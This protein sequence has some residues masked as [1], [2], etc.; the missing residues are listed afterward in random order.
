MGVSQKP[1]RT[2]PDESLLWIRCGELYRITL[3]GDVM[4]FD[5][6]YDGQTRPCLS[7]PVSACRWHHLEI[8]WKAFAPAIA[9]KLYRPPIGADRMDGAPKRV[10]FEFSARSFRAVD[11]KEFRGLT[12]EASRPAKN[13]LHPTM[14]AGVEKCE[15]PLPES[16]DIRPI[17]CHIW[18]MPNAFDDVPEEKPDVLE[19]K[20]RK[21]C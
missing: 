1:P 8:R 19:F 4:G 17:L 11:G 10:V 16:F 20:A 9:Q 15:L 12:F 3:L 5:T 18:G 14:I 21:V 6:H 7:P 2:P 13:K